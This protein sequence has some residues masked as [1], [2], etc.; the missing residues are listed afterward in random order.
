MNQPEDNMTDDLLLSREC[1]RYIVDFHLA[2]IPQIQTD[3]LVIGGGAAGLR[4]AIETGRHGKTILV[5]KDR[6]EDSNTTHAQGGIAVAINVGDEVDFHVEDTLRAG[7][8]LCNRAAV[9]VMVEEGIDRVGEMVSWGADFDKHNDELAFTMEAAH[10][11]RRIIH[12][13]GDA[14]GQETQIVLF[15]KASE[16]E[17][18]QFMDHRFIVDLLTVDGRCIG[19]LVLDR[20][21][22]TLI[23]I[24]ARSTILAAG[25]LCQI[26]Q[27]TTNPDGATGDGSAIAYRAG[28]E[29]TDMEFA[30]FHPTTLCL[31]DAP[32]FL[33]SESVR[34]EGA[35]LINESGQRFMDSY[36]EQA[37]LAPRDVVSRAILAETTKTNTKCVFLDLRRL[38]A[39]FV[40][41]RFPTI[42]ERCASYGI[43]IARDLIPVNVSA[44]FMMGGVKTNIRAETNVPGLYACGEVACVGV[45][46]ANRLASNSLL[47]TLVFSVRAAAGAMEYADNNPPAAA[48]AIEHQ[49]KTDAPEQAELAEVR[50]SIRDLM[51]KKV[52]IVRK[53][54]ELR[55]A[56]AWVKEHENVQYATRNGL[57]FQNM[58]HLSRLMI[59][60]A[61]AR[62]ES[63]G[64]HYRSDYPLRDD[65]QWQRHITFQRK[66]K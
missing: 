15:R 5:T 60:G 44:H 66:G 16:S 34:G 17:N 62:K 33:I 48:P 27:Y 64:A 8:G 2:Q 45:H 12:A 3:F 54:S 37:E 26:Y 42:N 36:H 20:D 31:P 32:R 49:N 9:E 14:T 39:R 30:Q 7:A 52:G 40:K 29:M 25:G 65:A 6:M 18:V 1:P 50:R 28:C 13:R 57:E 22:S 41:E 4:A 58:L 47:E 55:E 19:A 23:A 24:L 53:Q 51:W 56:L 10:R 43:D 46:G 63:R 35:I 21:D 38:D 11:M 59:D 61:L